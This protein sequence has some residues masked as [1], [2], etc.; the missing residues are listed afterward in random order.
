MTHDDALELLDIDDDFTEESLK[1][2]YKKAAMQHHPDRGGNEEMMQKVNQAYD[3]LQKTETSKGNRV[4]WDAINARYRKAGAIVVEQLKKD[5]KPDVFSAYFKEKTG[6]TFT[7]SY[8]FSPKEDVKSPTFAGVTAIFTSE[9]KNTAF[10]M[11]ATTDLHDIVYPRGAL[12][13]KMEDIG[14]TLWVETEIFHENRKVKFKKTNWDKTQIKSVLYDPEKL[15]P[16]AKIEKMIS[17]GGKDKTRAFARRDMYVG[18]SKKLDGKTAD[19]WAYIPFGKDGKFQLSMYRAMFMRQASWSLV[20]LKLKETPHTEWKLQIAFLPESEDILN[21]LAKVQN[22]MKD[23][24]NGETI[25]TAIDTALKKEKT[26]VAGS[27]LLDIKNKY[28]I[29]A[30]DVLDLKPKIKEKKKEDKE[31]KEE[32]IQPRWNESK[33]RVTTS[34]AYAGGYELIITTPVPAAFIRDKKKDNKGEYITQ[35]HKFINER[36]GR[37][38]GTPYVGGFNDRAKNGMLTITSKWH[39]EDPMFAYGL[40][41]DL[42][43]WS[44]S[45]DVVE[46]PEIAKRML[47]AEKGIKEMQQYR[48]L[49]TKKLKLR[50]QDQDEMNKIWQ[51]EFM[52]EWVDLSNKWK[53]KGIDYVAMNVARKQAAG[54]AKDDKIT[55]TIENLMNN[56]HFMQNLHLFIDAAKAGIASGHKLNKPEMVRFNALSIEFFNAI[57]TK[58]MAA[59]SK[60]AKDLIADGHGEAFGHLNRL[61]DIMTTNRITASCPIDAKDAVADLLSRYFEKRAESVAQTVKK[62][63]ASVLHDVMNLSSGTLS[64]LLHKAGAD[65]NNMR[66]IDKV[67]QMFIKMVAGALD[68]D[69]KAYKN[70]MDAWKYFVDSYDLETLDVKQGAQAS[71][72]VIAA[73]MTPWGRSQDQY[74]LAPGLI[75]YST[76]GH[77]GLFVSKSL[78]DKKLSPSARHHGIKYG[79]GYWYEEDCGYTIPFYENPEWSVLFKEK[80]GGS[81]ETKE[82]LKKVIEKWIPDYFSDEKRHEVIDFKNLKEGDLV[83]VDSLDAKPYSFVRLMDSKLIV[84]RDGTNYKLTKNTYFNRVKKVERDGQSLTK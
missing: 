55:S 6:K 12:T 58:D 68:S 21:K 70:W 52:Q 5:F 69:P 53:E 65:S 7:V 11:R 9:D 17:G 28:T 4:D 49:A 63:T 50:S 32:E 43:V 27:F 41:L 56:A 8:F 64:T 47:L 59:A 84:S 81:S 66:H 78:A 74:N 44:G 33:L 2:A 54:G 75:W 35:L 22:D 60:A 1:K 48:S 30:G 3:L 45:N 77:G 23:E 73:T 67:H 51:D 18:I 82:E 37:W 39:F 26:T 34:S 57:K 72:K 83:Y 80:S 31:K 13:S 71:S 16:S 40:G 61:G 19:E 20:R 42:S 36:I 46:K 10:S 62:V 24:T 15:F 38:M 76:P 25:K 79:S 14:Y 29:L